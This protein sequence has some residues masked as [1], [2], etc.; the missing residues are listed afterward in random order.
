MTQPDTA[1]PS[2][3]A[4]DDTPRPDTNGAAAPPA[5]FKRI[6]SF[7]LRAGRTTVAQQKAID[8]LG[9]RYVLPYQP[10]ALDFAQ[11]FGRHAPVVM[12][13]GFGMGDATASI[14][15]AR[16]EENFLCCE[17]HTPGVGALLKRMQ[18]GGIDNIRIVQHDAVEV[19]QHMVPPASLAGVHIFFPDPWHKK[20]HHKRRL[21]QPD[22]VA[23]LVPHLAPGGYIHCATD[24][25][26][27]AHQMR[28]VLQAHAEL[29]NL[30]QL[31][32]GFAQRPWYRPVTKFEQ[33]GLRLG[34]GVWDVLFQRPRSGQA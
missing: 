1:P 33:R 30:G 28:D 7:V 2:A 14:A 34:H 22:F 25:E 17:V 24:W 26:E 20:R 32:E 19:L 27:Y 6:R 11:A 13:I 12:E 23:S 9:A 5:H 16:P 18:D 29:V 15:Q 4:G 21:I 10:Q 31:P 3:A 8:A